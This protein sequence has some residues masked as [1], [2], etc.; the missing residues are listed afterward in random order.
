L[1]VVQY[2]GGPYD[3]DGLS[4]SVGG[5]YRTVK[6][7]SQCWLRDNLNVGGMIVGSVA[8]SNNSIL[9]KYCF[10]DIIGSCQIYGGLYQ[11]GEAMQYSLIENSQGICPLGCHI[12][13]DSEFHILEAILSTPP[14]DSNCNPNRSGDG[15]SPAG[16][17]LKAAADCSVVG[18]SNC[19]SSGFSGLIAGR[20]DIDA[21]FNLDDVA[22]VFWSSSALG[23]EAW[24]RYLYTVD[25]TLSRSPW[26]SWDTG[27]SIRCVQN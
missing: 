21:S 14:G 7:G 26:N 10:D 19:G 27:F 24:S 9:E 6:I 23:T 16:D 15:C 8:Q 1:P 13:S 3:A 5:Y 4:S 22:G 18:G 12:P 11:W 25:A 20:R 17:K 2:E